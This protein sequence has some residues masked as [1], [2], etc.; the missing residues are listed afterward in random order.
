[1][2]W[3]RDG[4]KHDTDTAKLIWKGYKYVNVPFG[5]A[6]KTIVS[7]FYK[8]RSGECFL[9]VE[10]KRGSFRSE[11]DERE[12]EITTFTEEEA[13][14]YAEENLSVEEYERAFGEVEE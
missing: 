4:K 11:W 6:R 14:K 2:Q 9:V 12:P 13:K 10:T 1:M 5:E 7:N 3:I 8:K